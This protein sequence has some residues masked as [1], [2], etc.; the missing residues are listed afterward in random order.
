[1]NIDRDTMKLIYWLYV[2]Y[3]N[4]YFYKINYKYDELID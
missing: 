4:S 2:S 3:L 1:M